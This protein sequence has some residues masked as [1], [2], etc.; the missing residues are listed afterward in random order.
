M[1]LCNALLSQNHARD[2]GLASL[3]DPETMLLMVVDNR[4]DGHNFEGQS[5]AVNDVCLVSL[6]Q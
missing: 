1:K 3:Y 5:L 2:I 4:G 6:K